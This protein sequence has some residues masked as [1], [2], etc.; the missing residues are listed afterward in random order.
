MCKLCV[1]TSF[2]LMTCLVI[3][4]AYAADKENEADKAFM[5]K[6]AQG[7]LFEIR[8]GELA[9]KK[10]TSEDVRKL[11]TRLIVDHTANNV[12]LKKLATKH[13]VELPN[14]L[15]EQQRKELARLEKLSGPEFEQAYVELMIKDHKA[16]IAAFEKQIA[17]SQG[18]VKQFAEKTLPVLR[19]HL[20]MAEETQKKLK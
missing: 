13:N 5:T 16:D 3:N 10:T 14:E 18:D 15:N 6:V 8:A 20:K 17:A 7:N 9:H 19:E 2:L 1:G 11:A 4:P 12:E